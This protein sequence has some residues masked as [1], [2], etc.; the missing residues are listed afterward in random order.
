MGR[1]LT[2]SDLGSYGLVFGA[3]MILTVVLGLRIDHV[4]SRELVRSAPHETVRKIR[5]ETVFYGTNYLILVLFTSVLW[6]VGLVDV[7]AWLI[8]FTLAIAITD[9]CTN[10]LHVNLVALERP[11]T[12]TVIYSFCQILWC[13]VAILL[14]LFDAQFR[15]VECVLTSW[16]A[17]NCVFILICLLAFRGLPWS[18]VRGM[19]VD[20][21]WLRNSIKSAA[22]IWLGTV[23][24]MA[25]SYVDRFVGAKLLSLSEV[26]VLTFYSSF[27]NTVFTLAQAG[28]VAVSA[29]AFVAIYREGSEEALRQEYRKLALQVGLFAAVA[30]LAIGIAVPMA[31]SL[32]AREELITNTP[33]LWLLLLAAWLRCNAE[34]L[35]LI[36]YAREQD[37]AIWS[38]NLA[39]LLPALSGNVL[40][41]LLFGL[42]GVGLS[43][44]ASSAFLLGW[45]YHY[46]QK[47]LISL[48]P[49]KPMIF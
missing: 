25:G 46:A 27:A 43:A 48:A 23:G 21:T 45:R 47:R 32:F 42:I 30:A 17:G 35:F 41:V 38:G 34:C 13:A 14:G 39:F 31:S 28:M 9:S 49:A 20:V 4:V 11:I 7:P 12:A 2:L 22:L 19:P 10:L 3:A 33:L 1:Y 40:L 26:G 18:S 29:P 8:L 15:N 5:D 37:Q 16:L 44:I 24:I 36:L 6:A